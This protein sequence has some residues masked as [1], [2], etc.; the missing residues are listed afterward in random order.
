MKQNLIDLA[1]AGQMVM[2][3]KNLDKHN[4]DFIR[5]KDMIDAYKKYRDLATNARD[6]AKI[7]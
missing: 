5:A 1:V 3:S 7:P 4:R 6:L 2:E